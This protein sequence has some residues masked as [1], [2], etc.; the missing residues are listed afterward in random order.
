MNTDRMLNDLT[1]IAAVGT[2]LGVGHIAKVAV[3]E[4][5]GHQ[6]VNNLESA[7]SVAHGAL[8]RIATS[9]PGTDIGRFAQI[10]LREAV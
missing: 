6:A 10:S 1:M 5:F 2:G 7:E 8:L 3:H 4:A 9:Y